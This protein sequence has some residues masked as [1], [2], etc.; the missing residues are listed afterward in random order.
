MHGAPIPLYFNYETYEDC[1]PI[2][3]ATE[4]EYPVTYYGHR[5]KDSIDMH[6]AFANKTR[7]DGR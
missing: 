6:K 4:E 1:I 5:F 7:A 2:N 3:P